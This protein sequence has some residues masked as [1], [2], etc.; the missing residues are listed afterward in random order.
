MEVYMLIRLIEVVV[1]RCF[2]GPLLNSWNVSWP[3]RAADVYMY[4]G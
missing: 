1:S 2:V 3:Y 4:V